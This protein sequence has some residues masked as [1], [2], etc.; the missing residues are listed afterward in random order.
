MKSCLPLP[1]DARHSHPIIVKEKQKNDQENNHK[2]HCKIMTHF[3]SKNN[4][5]FMATIGHADEAILHEERPMSQ[6]MIQT[7]SGLE[8]TE[9]RKKANDYSYFS[10][11]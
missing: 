6:T 2:H 3:K 7:M 4:L 8:S 1:V 11:N 9:H 10:I 5:W